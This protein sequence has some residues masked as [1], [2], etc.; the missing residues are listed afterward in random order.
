MCPARPDRSLVK[1]LL[2]PIRCGSRLR[3]W[4]EPRNSEEIV[5][6]A[7]QSGG[8]LGPLLSLVAGAS[9]VGDGLRPAEDFLDP[10]ANALA[11]GVTRVAGRAAV[12]RRSPG[13][14]HVRRDL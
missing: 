11:D 7:D 10:L 1:A 13:F 5:R 2:R 12:D 4:Y 3:A 8:H 14:G 9:E 6:C